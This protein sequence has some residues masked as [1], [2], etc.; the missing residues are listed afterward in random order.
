MKKIFTFNSLNKKLLT[1]IL[2]LAVIPLLITLGIIYFTTEQGFDELFTKQQAEM[3]HTIQTQFQKETEDLLK[4]TK[5]YASNDAII[6]AYQSENRDELMQKIIPVFTRLEAE[7]GL[8]VFELGDTSGNVILRGHNPEKYGDDKS[9][10]P[11][12]QTALNGEFTSGFEF[13]SSGLSVRAF[14]PIIHNHEVIGT[15]QTG[16]DDTFL[17]ELKNI[18]PGVTIDIYNEKGIIALSSIDSHIGGE[19]KDSSLLSTVQ[20]G[21]SINYQDGNMLESYIPMYDPT[22]TE[23]IGTIGITQ[24]ISVIYDTKESSVYIGLLIMAITIIVVIIVSM[25]FSKSISNPIKQIAEFM[26]ELS[27]GNLKTKINVNKRNDEIGK[28]LAD[29]KLMQDNLHNTISNVAAASSDVA[30]QSEELTQSAN[31]VTT[32]SQQISLTMEEIA[33]GTEKQADATSEISSAMES[34]S[35]KIQ[36]TNEEGAKVQKSSIEVLELTN[37]GK[38]L[39]ES[40]N[41]QMIEIDKI[42]Q[43]SVVKM[44]ALNAESQKIS[45]LVSIIEEVANQTNLLALNAAIEAARAGEHGK[46]FAVVADEVRKLAEQVSVSISDITQIVCSIQSESQ[47]VAESLKAGYAEVKLGTTKIK[48]TAETL[49]KINYSTTEMVDYITIITGN[50]SEIATGSQEMNVAIQEIAAITEESGA[51]IEE[52]SAT[53]QQ[54]SSSMEEVAGNSVE[55]ANLAE[56]LNELVRRFKI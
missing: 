42:V 8:N 38:Q 52:T 45:Q 49:N 56:K 28:L 10:L 34:F 7:H 26:L 6:D 36:D 13:G 31:E 3:E 12:I 51:G 30:S 21:E 43:E 44:D 24:D 35:I 50:L 37:H 55:L 11:A 19:I 18:L 20:N 9:S 23:T 41:Q 48:T 46:G 29:M 27:K 14:A 22:L 15:L 25:K 4:I 5:L 17:D 39:M 33:A 40:S 53:A 54:S 47:A 1:V 16:V 2:T 32:G